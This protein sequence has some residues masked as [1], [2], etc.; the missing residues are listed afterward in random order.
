MID[1][2]SREMTLRRMINR[3]NSI[4]VMF[5]Q[6]QTGSC[7][8]HYTGILLNHFISKL[9]HKEKKQQE[10]FFYTP[11]TKWLEH[12]VL[13]SPPVIMHFLFIVFATDVHL[14]IWNLVYRSIHHENSQVKLLFDSDWIILKEFCLLDWK[15]FQ[16]IHRK[17]PPIVSVRHFELYVSGRITFDRVVT[18][19]R[20]EQC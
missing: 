6:R 14:F 2:E 8:H 3:T 19:R 10:V 16:T 20:G 11:A 13:P 1:Q 17:F 4:H 5:V 18:L 12:I 9:W 7:G 15:E